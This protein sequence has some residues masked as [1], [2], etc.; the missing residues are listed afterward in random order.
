MD[1]RL[2][3]VWGDI[4][5]TYLGI[6]KNGKIELDPGVELPEGAVVRVEA[7][8]S[9][10]DPADGLADEAVDTGIPDLATQHDHYAYGT[11]KREN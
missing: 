5:M 3:P 7:P 11:T 6:V 1:D 8:E 10:T 9:A 4:A 2:D